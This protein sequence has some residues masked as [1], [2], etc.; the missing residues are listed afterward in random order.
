VTAAA[1]RLERE[2]E[3]AA[4]ERAVERK[5][6]RPLDPMALVFIRYR[7]SADPSTWRRHRRT[8]PLDGAATA[9]QDG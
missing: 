5:L 1:R 7:F 6:G 9:T 2:Y 3:T 4:F 8:H